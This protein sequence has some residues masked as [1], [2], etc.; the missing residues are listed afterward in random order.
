[1]WFKASPGREFT[2]PYLEKPFTKT[3]LVQWLKVKALIRSFRPAKTK[4]WQGK[5]A[6]SDCLK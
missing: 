2:K 1:L 3:G 5:K 6:E 4:L